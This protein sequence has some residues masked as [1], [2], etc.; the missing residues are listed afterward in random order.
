[1]GVS[2]W[3][4]LLKES[5]N[6]EYKPLEE[7]EYDFIVTDA[8]NSVSQAGNKV[9]KLTAKVETG[10]RAGETAKGN[11]T[12]SMTNPKALPFFF[13][14]MAAFG[15]DARFFASE[16]TD[17]QI[18]ASMK[19]KRFVGVVAH[20]PSEDKTRVWVDINEFKPARGA[21]GP[22]A[23]PAA[24]APP[25]AAPPVAPPP[26]A[27]AAPPAA[28]PVAPVPAAAPP[29]A[30]TAA[31]VVPQPVAPPA[32]APAPAPVAEPPA[33]PATPDPWGSAPPVMPGDDPF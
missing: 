17:D 28:A 4:D 20:R 31:P 29:V 14:K 21:G 22:G 23:A 10:P 9:Y 7:G 19:N 16:P 1:M 8:S 32:P 26:V 13:R 12:L 18:S 5:E 6:N 33:A 25:V 27:A 24:A 2:L 15:L 30:T 3:S 11:I